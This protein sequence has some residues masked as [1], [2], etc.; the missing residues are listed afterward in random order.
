MMIFNKKIVSRLFLFTVLLLGITANARNNRDR[1]MEFYFVPQY[2]KGNT[3]DFRGEAKADIDSS[4]SFGFGFGYNF[5][6]N[7]NLGLLFSYAEADYMGKYYDSA[8]GEYIANRHTLYTSS[9]NIV[10]TYYFLDGNFS[11]FVSG[12]IGYTHTNTGIGN[13]EIYVGCP[14]FYDPYWGPCL[15]YEG[16]YTDNSMNYGAFVGVR[17]DFDNRFFIKGSVGTNIID[18]NS[19]NRADFTVYQITLGSTF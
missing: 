7:W 8:A 6:P 17:Y 9:I 15:P 12:H 14:P 19:Q 10:G 2:I 3:L 16:A 11:P 18:Y 5:T 4:V 1:S 13:G